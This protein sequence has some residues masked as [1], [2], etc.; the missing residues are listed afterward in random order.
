MAKLLGSTLLLV[1]MVMHCLVVDG[2]MIRQGRAPIDVSSSVVLTLGDGEP[3]FD[4]ALVEKAGCYV[5]R[6]KGYSLN[7]PGY[8]IGQQGANG[9]TTKATFINSSAISCE[10]PPVTTAGNTSIVLNIKSACELALEH[11]CGDEWKG[12]HAA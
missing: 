12:K 10:L 11:F 1:A 6:M 9:L 2:L 5:D 8:A 7:V 4:Q 3:P